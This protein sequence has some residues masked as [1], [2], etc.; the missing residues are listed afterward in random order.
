MTEFL[1]PGEVS[2]VISGPFCHVRELFDG[3]GA[4]AVSG[5]GAPLQTYLRYE[6]DSLL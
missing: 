2:K 5:G 4:G 6:M 1:S 3:W